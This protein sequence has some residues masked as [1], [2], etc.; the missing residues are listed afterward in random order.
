MPWED[1]EDS[2]RRDLESCGKDGGGIYAVLSPARIWAT[3]TERDV[4][5]KASGAA[6]ALVRA[7]EEFRPLLSQALETYRTGTS[8]P[9]FARDEVRPF[10]NFVIDQ[11]TP[12]PSRASGG[13]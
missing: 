3:L 2:L 1:Y 11:L 10:V 9:R 4:H 13:G 7:P 5:S 6:W 12:T 8:D